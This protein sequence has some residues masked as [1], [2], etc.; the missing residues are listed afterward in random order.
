MASH[1]TSSARSPEGRSSLIPPPPAPPLFDPLQNAWVL[2]RYDD[3]TAA[4]REPALQPAGP[5]KSPAHL[6]EDVAA[7][8]SQAEI[9]DWRQR[10]EPLA[11]RIMDE[12]PRGRPV[13]LVNEV[14]RPWSAA[15]AKVVLGFD[16]AATQELAALEP[17]L[18]VGEADLLAPRGLVSRLRTRVQRRLATARLRK[19]LQRVGVR[20][21]R[22]LFLGLSQSVPYFLA[23]AWLALLENP[24]QVLL[25]RDEPHLSPLAIEELLRYCGTVHTLLREADHAVELAGIKIDKGQSVTLKVDSANRDPEQ[26][27]YPN[28]LEIAR[29]GAGHLGL[30]GGSHSCIGAQL[31]R[32][33]AIPATRAFADKLAGAELVDRVVWRRGLVHGTP[34]SLRVRRPE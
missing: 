2:S 24:S 5:Q 11:Y 27:S 9:L 32:M 13:D 10:I 8:L 12:L 31:V 14:L 22:S 20:G 6:R 17:H 23:N 4:L 21:A 29:R 3:V 25:L 16:A 28:S 18:A 30:G 1:R 15:A 19:I 7:T 33:A 26:F 34:Y